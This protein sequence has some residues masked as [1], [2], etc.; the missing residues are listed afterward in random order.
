MY[1]MQSYMY[2]YLPL[3]LEGAVIGKKWFIKAME[4]RYK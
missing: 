1:S 3:R 4:F 2:P